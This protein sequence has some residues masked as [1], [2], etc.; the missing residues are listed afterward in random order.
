MLPLVRALCVRVAVVAAHPPVPGAARG[1][2]LAQ[3]QD[4][5]VGAK[6]V[7]VLDLLRLVA[8][9]S[10]PLQRGRSLLPCKS[11]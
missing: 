6:K 3:L 9:G 7:Q 1:T 10:T 5:V 2:V 8:C 4:A 11:R